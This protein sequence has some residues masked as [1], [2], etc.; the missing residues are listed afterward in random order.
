MDFEIK[1]VKALELSNLSSKALQDF[2]PGR[3][4][5]D[6]A[7]PGMIDPM[8]RLIGSEPT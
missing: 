2:G 5:D 1:F 7:I 8:L 3:S 4:L 6:A